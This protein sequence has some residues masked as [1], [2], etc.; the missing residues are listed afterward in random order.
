MV[1]TF[2]SKTIEAKTAL[3]RC[4]IPGI[5]Y[6][7]NP[8]LGCQFTCVY[9]YASF[10]GRFVGKDVS[11]W[12]SYVYPK[13][14][15][16]DVLKREIGRKLKNKGRG[17]EVLLSSVTDPYQ[18]L[19]AKYKLTR[20]CLEVLLE[21]GFRG[22]LSIL[23]KSPLVLRDLDLLKRFPQVTVGLTITT[24]DDQ[25]SRFFEKYAPPASE[26]LKTLKKLNK[27]GIKTYAF[28]GPLLPHFVAKEEILDK[29]FAAIVTA[30][31]YDIFVEHLNLAP[32]IRRRLFREI[33]STQGD[34][35][36][37]CEFYQ[38]QGPQYRQKLE[39]IVRRL[40][41]KHRLNLLKDTVIY[42][43]EKGNG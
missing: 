23:T 14:N 20:G 18:G 33:F 16:V 35:F 36:L 41:Q 22:R 31:T 8:Y 43:Q 6:T 25:I 7:I 5:D 17:K 19:E 39:K 27:T 40:T 2:E 29:L 3:V 10:M 24:T 4:S 15:I 1:K 32:Y 42:H 37:P 9:C 11:D 28:I 26:R 30:G 12:G 38:S 21:F 34:N 13:V